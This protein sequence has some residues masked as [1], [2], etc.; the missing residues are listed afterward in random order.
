MRFSLPL[1]L[2][3]CITFSC[4]LK[5]FHSINVQEELLK[6]FS[7]A[8]LVSKVKGK[9]LLQKSQN[10]A[11]GKNEKSLLL[12]RLWIYYKRRMEKVFFRKLL[13]VLELTVERVFHFPSHASMCLWEGKLCEISTR[14]TFCCK[15]VHFFVSFIKAVMTLNWKNCNQ[16]FRF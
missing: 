8:F 6:S 7:G 14:K 16:S 2:S 13:S 11:N 10:V 9:K 15:L 1:L 5:V 3:H 4:L 12:I